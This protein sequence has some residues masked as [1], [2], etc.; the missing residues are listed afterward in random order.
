MKI[1]VAFGLVL[2]LA[3]LAACV[4]ARKRESVK[5]EFFWMVAMIAAADVI[6]LLYG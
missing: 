1:A 6:F 2:C 3:A 4:A 5:D